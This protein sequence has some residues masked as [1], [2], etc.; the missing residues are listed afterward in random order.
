MYSGIVALACYLHIMSADI[1]FVSIVDRG[2]EMDN[3]IE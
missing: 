1:D 2:D 3:N